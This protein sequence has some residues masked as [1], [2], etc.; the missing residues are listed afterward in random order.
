MSK[1]DFLTV[2]II[3]LLVGALGFLVYKT[4]NVMGED[5]D[6]V[7]EYVD[8]S[9]TTDDNTLTTNEAEATTGD[10]DSLQTDTDTIDNEEINYSEDDDAA[11][12]LKDKKSPYTDLEQE[13]NDKNDSPSS[14]SSSGKYMVL[15]GSYTQKV[16][17]ERQVRRLI[18]KGYK[19]AEMS[20]FNK[21]TYAVVIVERFDR[22]SEAKALQKKL[23]FEGIDAF[24]KEKK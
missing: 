15:A 5:S 16:N 24:V 13:D 10:S 9:S 11:D 19:D 17:A 14:Y 2:A 20:L 8:D 22:L 21:G 1:L 23:A 3:V 12:E 18:S 4:I 7:T 6:P